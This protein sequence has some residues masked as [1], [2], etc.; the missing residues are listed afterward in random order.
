MHSR[1]KVPGQPIVGGRIS[2]NVIVWLHELE[3]P[4]L[5]VA[6]HVRVM[7][8]LPVHPPGVVASEYV[9]EIERSQLSVAV[10]KPVIAGSVELPQASVILGGQLIT[11]AVISCTVI[12]WSQVTKF[13]HLSVAR[14]VLVIVKF[15]GHVPGVITSV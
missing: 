15:S 4:Q 14:Q 12:V 9:M 13:P 11:G 5:S 8:E 1:I 6:V 2:S 3:L 10:A 7:P